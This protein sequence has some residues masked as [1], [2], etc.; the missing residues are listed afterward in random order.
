MTDFMLLPPAV[1]HKPKPEQHP[2][3]AVTSNRT[4]NRGRDFVSKILLPHESQLESQK[5]Y[6]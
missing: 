3:L 1:K 2:D 6:V 5:D 4:R